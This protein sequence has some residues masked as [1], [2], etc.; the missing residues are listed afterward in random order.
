M[1]SINAFIACRLGSTR[2]KFKNLLLLNN[3]PLF[4]YLTDNSLNSKKINNLFINSDSEIILDIA[5][6]IY[7]SKVLYFLRDPNLGTS[8]AA[9]DDYVYD[10][11]IKFPS[12]ITVFLNPCSLF[13][14][15]KTID[16]ALGYF[17]NNNLDSCC[18]SQLAQTHCFYKNKAI[19]FRSDYRQPRSQDL[20]PIH[21]MTSGFFIWRNKTFINHYENSKA[22]N[23]CGKFESYGISDFESIDI[24]TEEDLEIANRFLSSEGKPFDYKYHK[25]VDEL[26]KKGLIRT[27]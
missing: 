12:D 18:A 6:S 22:A 5:R 14:K 16:S 2:V 11:M 15:G 3:K 25:S 20:T 9:L 10:F 1:T 26:I 23:F 19:N 21:C 7:K 17:I 27:N 8:K 4:T 24:D 13:L